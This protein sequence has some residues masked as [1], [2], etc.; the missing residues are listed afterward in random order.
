MSVFH[1]V[2]CGWICGV[3]SSVERCVQCIFELVVC[4]GEVVSLQVCWYDLGARQ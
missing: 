2:M 3:S 1:L 4:E